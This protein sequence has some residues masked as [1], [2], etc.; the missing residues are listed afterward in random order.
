MDPVM[1]PFFFIACAALVLVAALGVRLAAQSWRQG[2]APEG[3]LAVFFLGGLMGFGPEIVCNNFE[4]P[5][6]TEESLR[7]VAF[8]GF[9]IPGLAIALFTWRVFRAHDSW[10][11]ALAP[12]LIA[13][14]L[15]SAVALGGPIA[16][17]ANAPAALRKIPA[18]FWAGTGAQSIAFLWAA[19][20]AFRFHGLSRRRLA[21]GIGDALTANRFFLWSLWTGCACLSLILKVTDTVLAGD[22]AHGTGVRVP[23]AWSQLASG[24]TIVVAIGLTFT[25]PRFYR[26]YLA[27]RASSRAPRTRRSS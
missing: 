6:A 1:P 19:I 16:G 15:S 23:L 4:L 3:L 21:L 22:I 18:A 9:R 8:L 14:V 12:L 11:M 5:A 24:L 7:F 20:E 27:S 2:S 26:N 10:A 13:V 17:E 25:P